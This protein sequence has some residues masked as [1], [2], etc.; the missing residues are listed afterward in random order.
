MIA[1]FLRVGNSTL[2]KERNINQL[3]QDR[4]VYVRRDEEQVHQ[5]DQLWIHQHMFSV[6][7]G[8]RLTRLLV[9]AA[10]RKQQVQ[11]LH[12]LRWP[13]HFDSTFYVHKCFVLIAWFQFF[14]RHRQLETRKPR[15]DNQTLIHHH[16]QCT[17]SADTFSP[18]CCLVFVAFAA[19]YALVCTDTAHAYKHPDFHPFP[20]ETNRAKDLR[21]HAHNLI[22][23]PKYLACFLKR[24]T[25]FPVRG[26]SSWIIS[27]TSKKPE[28][29]DCN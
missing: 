10:N 20:K 23:Y 4:H 28:L 6:F 22:I 9:P 27:E 3:Q 16:V 1:K 7:V 12:L 18:S 24:R 15:E 29:R 11:V 21:C 2:R 19:P 17:S 8:A 13:T 26:S 5:D 14:M 25:S